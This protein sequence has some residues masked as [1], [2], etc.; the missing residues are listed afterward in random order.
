MKTI[1]ETIG[2]AK[3]YCDLAIDI[4]ENCP[5]KCEYCYAKK[6]CERK[7]G[8]FEFNGTR[9]NVLEETEKFLKE[10]K[11]I[12]GK[13]IFLGF[14]SDAVPTGKDVSDTIR[15]EEILKKY[16]CKIMICTKS[17]LFN[18]D[19]KKIIELA[20]SV[21]IT[22]SCGEEMAKKYETNAASVKDR[23]ELLKFAKSLNKET[24]ISFEPVLETKF[25][26]ELLK[27]DFMNYVDIVKFGKLNHMELSDLTGNKDDTIDW[28]EYVEKVIKICEEKKIKYKIKEALKAYILKTV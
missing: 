6:K 18:E 11:E 3:E 10:H 5:H 8:N 22:I 16:N 7:N 27:S 20:D 28:T 14:S 4:Y 12:H 9:K 25:I 26:L 21:G 23:M 2:A 24:W 17:K 1:Y 15:M 19:V 13:M